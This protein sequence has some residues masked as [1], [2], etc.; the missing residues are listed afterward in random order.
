M[1]EELQV[2][3]CYN[4]TFI[5]TNQ[6]TVQALPWIRCIDAQVTTPH[7]KRRPASAGTLGERECSGPSA[8]VLTLRI[9]R[10]IKLLPNQKRERT[11]NKRLKGHGPWHTQ[12]TWLGYNSNH[13][14][15]Q[16]QFTHDLQ[17]R[18]H[19]IYWS[20]PQTKTKTIIIKLNFSL[21]MIIQFFSIDM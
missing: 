7:T 11:G 9:I 1:N 17:T 18:Q 14:P 12:Y 19:L 13:W 10:A 2:N 4:I 3:G 5:Y 15:R 8:Q 20:R 21:S 16:I 6:E